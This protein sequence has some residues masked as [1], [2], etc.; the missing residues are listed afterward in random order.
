MLKGLKISASGA[1]YTEREEVAAAVVLH[2]GLS[3]QELNGTC[4][5]LLLYPGGFGGP[6]HQFA[7]KKGLQVVSHAW[8]FD[9]LKAGR[10]MKESEYPCNKTSLDE[11]KMSRLLQATHVEGT[12][13]QSGCS[14]GCQIIGKQCPEPSQSVHGA[15]QTPAP[16]QDSYGDGSDMFF[17]T[18]RVYLACGADEMR[19]LVLACTA[20]AA[21]RYDTLHPRLTHI[22]IG[23]QISRDQM[24]QVRGFCKE[25]RI[26]PQ[27]VTAG[28]LQQS[29]AR[30]RL[31]PIGPDDR[32]DVA[33]SDGSVQAGPNAAPP[34]SI[35][36]SQ[37]AHADSQ[38]TATAARGSQMLAAEK[39]FTGY[40]F[41]LAG[42]KGDKEEQDASKLIR[43]LGGKIFSAD[44]MNTVLS[45]QKAYAV[46]STSMPP[47]RL[48]PLSRLPDFKKVPAS[49]RVTV[50]WLCRCNMA[51]SVQS[52]TS[53][54]ELTSRP[55]PF[56]LPVP[57]MG[58]VRLCASGYSEV[59]KDKIKVLTNILGG[60]YTT[61]MKPTSTHLVIGKAIGTKYDCCGRLGVVPVT[62]AWLLDVGRQGRLPATTDYA[63]ASNLDLSTSQNADPALP[64][65]NPEI[66]QQFDANQ[67]SHFSQGASKRGRLA[68]RDLNSVEPPTSFQGLFGN[69]AIQ[70][71]QHS[72][73]APAGSGDPAPATASSAP[74][75]EE[76]E[77][78]GQLTGS[79]DQAYFSSAVERLETALTRSGAPSA[80][81]MSQA[82]EGFSIQQP[83]GSLQSGAMPSLLQL[84]DDECHRDREA[85]AKVPRICTSSQMCFSQQV[86]YADTSLQLGGHTNSAANDEYLKQRLAAI[87]P[88]KPTA[89]ALNDDLRDIGL[90]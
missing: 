63:P 82:S 5:H 60:K 68:S 65:C 57:G 54:D 49:M 10:R 16:C 70:Q 4:T 53:Y 50:W 20:G 72:N 62:P 74:I 23:K 15:R 45:W 80:P 6:K 79:E 1:D 56:P 84:E 76:V 52:H 59:E 39:L 31:L 78:M 8:L 24:Q 64:S 90:M 37:Q 85:R 28:W 14:G 73:L 2:G 83:A 18:L 25:Q 89:P 58:G 27:L 40:Y 17:E 69:H 46:C 35:Q 48:G 75:Q 34:S 81:D 9:S 13:L 67:L 47:A 41:T 86:G 38:Q 66:S 3:S 7:V 55:F 61:A 88:Q 12:E 26:K 43:K 51:S 19:S 87:A 29:A 30:Q 21:T 22:V 77:E 71:P 11:A 44:T 32:A 42:L 33:A 36:T